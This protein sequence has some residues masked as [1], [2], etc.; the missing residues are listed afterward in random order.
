MR[1]VNFL[2]IG[3]GISSVGGSSGGGHG[4]SGGQGKGVNRGGL[5]YDS[6]LWPHGFGYDGGHSIFPHNGGKGG[7]RLKV[8]N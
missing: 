1:V 2:G 4:G 5:A 3:V 6:F 8:R 7:G